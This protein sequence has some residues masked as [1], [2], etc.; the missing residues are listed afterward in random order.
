MRAICARLATVFVVLGGLAGTSLAAD[1]LVASVRLGPGGPAVVSQALDA[2]SATGLAGAPSVWFVTPGGEKEVASQYDRHA[3]GSALLTWLRASTAAAEEYSWRLRAPGAIKP[4]AQVA[5][6][7]TADALIVTTGALVVRHDLHPGGLPV[8][9]RA[10][11]DGA[12]HPLHWADRIFSPS[13]GAFSLAEDREPQVS[14]EAQGPLR[15]EVLVRASYKRGDELAPGHPRAE[16]RFVYTAGS[17]AVELSMRLIGPDKPIWDEAHTAELSGVSFRTFYADANADP[18]PLAGRN[19]PVYKSAALLGTGP[20]A[21]IGLAQDLSRVSGIDDYLAF[22]DPAPPK[23]DA[24][25]AGL[26]PTYVR[27]PWWGGWHGERSH[28]LSLI[29]GPADMT[30]EAA[31][32]AILQVIAT[33]DKSV[34]TPAIERAAAAAGKTGRAS[35]GPAGW[36]WDACRTSAELRRAD[37]LRCLAATGALAET[38]R[39]AAASAPATSAGPRPAKGSTV[40]AWAAQ[41]GDLVTV[42]SS[43][44][45]TAVK[46]GEGVMIASLVR[47]GGQDLA[48]PEDA[49]PILRARLRLPDGTEFETDGSHASAS[50]GSA[51]ANGNGAALTVR[52]Q[53][54]PRPGVHLAAT[55][56]CTVA[57]NGD[58]TRWTASIQVG[59]ATLL[60]VRSPDM[61]IAPIGGSAA[62]SS[63]VAVT[64]R[65]LYGNLIARPFESPALAERDPFGDMW[66]SATMIYPQLS[67]PVQMTCLYR[68]GGGPSADLLYMAAADPQGNYKA[69]QY[70]TSRGPHQEARLR[71]GFLHVP[72]GP[73]TATTYTT[74]YATVLAPLTG[75]WFDAAMHYRAWAIHQP[76][77]AKGP[78]KT[79]RDMPDWIKDVP[80]WYLASDMADEHVEALAKNAD[81]LGVPVAAHW[82]DWHHN[83]FDTRMPDYFP[84]LRG[85][86]AFRRH[87]DLWHEH[88][89]RSVPYIQG[90]LWDELTDSWKAEDAARWAIVGQDGK[91]GYWTSFAGDPKKEGHCASMC[92]ATDFWRGKL[93]Q[94]VTRLASYGVDGVYLDSIGCG[95]GVCYAANH[96]HPAGPGG[97]HWAEGVRKLLNQLK[98]VR[99]KSGER[100]IFTTEG[101]TETGIGSFDAFLPDLHHPRPDEGAI[102]DAVYHDYVSFYGC[103]AGGEYQPDGTLSQAAAECF[104]LGRP[105]GWFY[106]G[107]HNDRYL[108][109]EARP[110]MDFV[111]ELCRA[112]VKLSAFL[113]TG[114]MLAPPRVE[115][116]DGDPTVLASAWTD[117]QAR[118]V[119][120]V[121][122]ADRRAQYRLDL[123]RLGSARLK[124]VWPSGEGT[125]PVPGRDLTLAPRTI[126]AWSSP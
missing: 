48:R 37:D 62:L 58:D 125:A 33:V 64:P 9:F 76:W 17:R 103:Y 95:A 10:S 112:R 5:V 110:E 117:G 60:W 61:A 98:T 81:F 101:F 56:R 72:E 42:G 25:R 40:S 18:T 1:N 27:G 116:I 50:V 21:T 104:A 100:M 108:T 52:L 30:G 29:F 109:A 65:A 55:I 8:A 44:C 85:E 49:S 126:V 23:N 75:D 84:P 53:E 87:I 102:Y 36:W 97:P 26:V 46:V 63:Q 51:T 73:G 7:W 6:S 2:A 106:H 16:Y 43:R 54:E 83:P 120:A 19:E 91:V 121:N 74:P 34:S 32:A 47:R 94:I 111:R 45:A 78:L 31:R 82:Y 38:D 39:E 41:A 118:L 14:I 122:Y 99:A 90:V 12:E 119:V 22:W 59:G 13:L 71:A 28:R 105:L 66:S 4:L 3:D 124:P 69:F 79:R 93:L 68:R 80:I 57:P 11:P 86:E 88:H 67:M 20:E 114:T 77:C 92:V 15:V 70:V 35:S 107:F 123:S 113:A 89:I 24:E 115:V 96:G